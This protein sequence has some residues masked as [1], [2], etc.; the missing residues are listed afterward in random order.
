[1]NVQG[2]QTS[3]VLATLP[4]PSSPLPQEEPAMGAQAA[5]QEDLLPDPFSLQHPLPPSKEG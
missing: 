1:M 5:D 2:P 3:G 4:T